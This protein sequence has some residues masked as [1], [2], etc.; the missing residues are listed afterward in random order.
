MLSANLILKKK[1]KISSRK[2]VNNCSTHSLICQ[3]FSFANL[4]FSSNIPTIVIPLILFGSGFKKVNLKRRLGAIFTSLNKLGKLIRFLSAFTYI[5]KSLMKNPIQRSP[6]LNRV[7]VLLDLSCLKVWQ[8]SDFF[9]VPSNK[10]YYYDK[11]NSYCIYHLN[12]YL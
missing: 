9:V 6:V 5:S 12:F 2:K 10:E 1:K 11:R 8:L 4:T 3:G 7:N